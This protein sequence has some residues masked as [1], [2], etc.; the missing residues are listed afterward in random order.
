MRLRQTADVADFLPVFR[1]V[2][3]LPSQIFGRA[4][5][6]LREELSQSEALRATARVRRVAETFEDLRVGLSHRDELRVHRIH[7]LLDE[8]RDRDR[9]LSRDCVRCHLCLH[10]RLSF[11]GVMTG[12]AESARPVHTLHITRSVYPDPP[13]AVPPWETAPASRGALQLP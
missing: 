6:P 9:L 10:D 1:R 4:G 11:A 7:L 2:F 5:P 12:R 8:L 3:K 13:A